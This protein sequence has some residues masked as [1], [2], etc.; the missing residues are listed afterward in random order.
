M[1]NVLVFRLEKHLEVPV[2][3]EGAAGKLLSLH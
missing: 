3:R 1:L 2:G